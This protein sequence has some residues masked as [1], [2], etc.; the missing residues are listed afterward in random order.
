VTLPDAELPDFHRRVRYDVTPVR[1]DSPFFW[2]FVRFRDALGSPL[3]LNELGTDW[4]DATGEQVM[5]VLLV[6][7]ALLS[8]LFL[9][10]PL[11][12][13]RDTFRAMPHKLAAGV[14]FAAL[15]TGFMFLEVSFI[16]RF[17]LFLGYPTYS[18]T[19]TLFAMLV[20]SGIGSIASGRYSRTRP[21]ALRTLLGALVV[22]GAISLFGVPPLFARL[23][24]A[25]LAARVG[26][27]VA[28]IF[29]LGLCLGAFM[30]IGLQRVANL[31]VHPREYV[32]WAWAV[33]GFFSVISSVL[34]TILA[35]TIGFRAVLV[36]A[37]VLYGIGVTVFQ[38][39]PVRRGAPP[40][41]R[42]GP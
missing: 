29:P 11:F 21:N 9:L 12:A 23:A 25:P 14:Y 4:E 17:T 5:L 2:H 15:G 13:I 8:A 10:L 36:L 31:N 42:I 32:A 35:M 30:P 20:S 27:A 16:Q 18:L 26:V 7:A 24:G 22:I 37:L 1:D 39:V 33:N 6:L 38:W 19:V 3:Q 28:V 40:S 34:S 41:S